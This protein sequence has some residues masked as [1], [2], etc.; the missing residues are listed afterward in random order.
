[1]RQRSCTI[2]GGFIEI[3]SFTKID[4]QPIKYFDIIIQGK[5]FIGGN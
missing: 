4:F 2:I 5:Y 1:M 3:I